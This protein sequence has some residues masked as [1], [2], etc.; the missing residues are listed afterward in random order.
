L[1]DLNC[2]HLDDTLQKQSM[3]C[4]SVSSFIDL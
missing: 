1:N 2:G 4:V 3:V